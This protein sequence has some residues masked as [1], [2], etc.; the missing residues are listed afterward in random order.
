MPNMAELLEKSVI[1]PV[2]IGRASA[3]EALDGGIASARSG[4]GQV[5]VL[6]GEAGIGKSRLVAEARARGAQ[7]GLFI[8]QGNCFEPDRSLPY[9]PLL[10]LLR[11]FCLGRPPEEI[12]RELGPTAPELVKLLPELVTFLP[13]LIPTPSL[14]PEQEKR[15]LFQALVQSLAHLAE[16]HP[17]L[18]AVEDVHWSDDT[19]LEFLLHLARRV[20]A[21]PILLVLTYRSDEA[22]PALAHFLAELDRQRLATELRLAR[23]S[24]DEVE[25]MLG[26]IFGLPRPVRAESLEPLY[27]LTEGNPFFIE[28]VLKALV[29]AGDIFYADGD[30]G[31]KQA[32][33]LH[34]PRSVQDAVKR[35]SERLS[36]GARQMLTLA[37]VA[38]RRFDFALLQHLT[39]A[40]ED[41]L[42]RWIKEALAAQLVIEESAEQFAF[43][44]TLTQQAIYGD[45]LARERRRLHHRI[46]EAMEQVY[47]DAL[48]AHGADLAYHFYQAGAW[49]QVLHYAQRAGEKAQA[50]FAPRAAAEHFAHAIEAARQLALTPP[51]ALYRARGQAYDALGDFE[52]ARDDYATALDMAHG[53]G[54]Q[55]AEWQALLDLGFLWASRDYKQTG[56]YFGRALELARRIGDQPTLAYSLNRVGNWRLNIEQPLEALRCHQEALSIFERSSDQHGLAETLDLMGMASYLGGDLVRG[57]E[58]YQRAVALFQQLGDRRGLSSSLATLTLRGPTYQTDTMA[59]LAGLAEA[60]HDGEMALHFARD[61][62]WRSG[63]AFALSMLGFCLGPRGDYARALSLAQA[64]LAIAEEIEHRQW[65]SAAHCALGALYLDLFALP[66]AQAHLEA[67]L[68]L[69]MEIGSR[70]WMHNVTGFLASTYILKNE[71][72]RAEAVL[73][74]SPSPDALSHEGASPGPGQTLGQRQVWCAQAELALHR[75]NPALAL[76]IADQLLASAAHAS[77]G[78]VSL[79]LSKLRGEALS[80]LAVSQAEGASWAAEAETA[81]KAAQAVAVEQEARSLLWRMHVTLGRLYHSQARHQDADREMAAARGIVE[82]LAAA[83]PDGP[84]RDN[85]V[86]YAMALFPRVPPLSPRQAAKKEYGGLTAREREVAALIAQ[87]LSNRAIADRMVVGERTVETH[88]SNILSKLDLSSRTQIAAWALEKQLTRQPRD[89]VE[90]IF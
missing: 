89:R 88:V 2:L 8:L 14:E 70:H 39:G 30:W 25:A 4:K 40:D 28:E 66:E 44:H 24:R 7:K 46:A 33:E 5:I 85:F 22:H 48:D 11:V 59:A 43:R 55:R 83:I 82:G 27:A 6:A 58:Y 68:A 26:A 79:R 16:A 60:A 31:R 56:D 15:R 20:A 64:G 73:Q 10:D 37:A 32:S 90:S 78:H 38:G 18:I 57:T 42:L 54:D 51:P 77:A 1:C 23:L 9:A 67:A 72:A 50:Q 13:G 87:G 34:P 47:L 52:R 74:A 62:G 45:L 21:Q 71:P 84:L 86:Q 19:S 36:A 65:I 41:D 76:Q 63:E 12:A 29:A 49:A 3:L 35:R 75:S 61:I 81:L 69:A 53:S 17:L 80:A